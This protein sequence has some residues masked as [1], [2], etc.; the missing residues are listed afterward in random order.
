MRRTGELKT[1]ECRTG[2]PGMACVDFKSIKVYRRFHH[3]YRVCSSAN[4]TAGSKVQPIVRC[5]ASKNSYVLVLMSSNF[6]NVSVCSALVCRA[7]TGRRASPRMYDGVL[8]QRDYFAVTA[9]LCRPPRIRIRTYIRH[10]KA[11]ILN[12][13]YFL[14]V[15]F[16][17]GILKDTSI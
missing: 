13:G 15:H 5:D 8:E 7:S 9:T 2:G 3:A 12:I 4:E 11:G 16:N 6:L 17:A 10:V 1:A 14:Q